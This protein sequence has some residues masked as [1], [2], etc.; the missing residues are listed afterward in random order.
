[1]SQEGTFNWRGQ[2]G[3]I[4][5]FEVWSKDTWF[6]EVECVYI[7]TKFVN[8]SWQC[9]YVGQTSQLATRLAQHTNGTDASDRCIQRSNATH[10]HTLQLTPESVRLDVET[11]LRS[12]YNWSCNMQ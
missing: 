9:I 2:S 4:Y 8:G 12:A 5:T 1:M 11:D 6:N 7:Y 3:K 10:I